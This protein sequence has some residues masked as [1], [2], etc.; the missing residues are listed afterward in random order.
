MKTQRGEAPQYTEL[1]RAL[2][3]WAK[4]SHGAGVDGE[5]REF[6]PYHAGLWVLNLKPQWSCAG[7]ILAG[8]GQ[9]LLAVP[10]SNMVGK[11]WEG[12]NQQQSF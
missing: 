1:Q 7:R 4:G 10:S 8:A 12:S 5:V 6:E 11:R 3:A 2:N 9:G